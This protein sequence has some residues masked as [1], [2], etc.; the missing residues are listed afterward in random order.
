MI[1]T[2]T[3]LVAG[4][5]FFGAFL[6]SWCALLLLRRWRRWRAGEPL[7]RPQLARRAAVPKRLRQVGDWPRTTRV[8]PWLLAFFIAMLWLVP[9]EQIQLSVSLPIGLPLD[10]LVLPFL[11]G[12]WILAMRTGG[13]AAP[14]MRL[15]WIHGAVGAFMT[16]ALLSVVLNAP[17]LNHTQEL[18]EGLKRIPLFASYLSLFVIV[19]SVVRPGEVRAFLNFMLGLAVILAVG[20]IVEY[21]FAYNVF[22]DLRLSSCRAS[23]PSEA[24]SGA[25]AAPPRWTPSAAALCRARPATRWRRWRCCRWRWPSRSSASPRP[26]AWRTG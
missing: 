2:G 8:L 3:K 14:R 5:T 10:R 24:P 4:L 13:R 7:G 6:V 22:Y 23:S 9:F 19:A 21:R 12:I 20:M 17:D 18:M 11:I 26:S 16:V 15:T 25:P 1:T